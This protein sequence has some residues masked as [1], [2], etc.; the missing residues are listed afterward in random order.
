[1]HLVTAQACRARKTLKSRLRADV[2]VY[3]AGIVTLQQSSGHGFQ[4]AQR[5]VK[6]A[7]LAYQYARWKLDEHIAAHDC[8]SGRIAFHRQSWLAR[9]GVAVENGRDTSRTAEDGAL[10]LETLAPHLITHFGVVPK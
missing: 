4:I 5:N 10:P 6:H 3:A 2:K 7:Q 1:M 9:C 8:H